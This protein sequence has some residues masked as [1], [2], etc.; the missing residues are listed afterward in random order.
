MEEATQRLHALQN[1]WLNPPADS[2][3]SRELQ[4]RTLI[5]LYNDPP[6]WP[7]LGH[8]RLDEVVLGPP[9]YIVKP[10]SP[11]ASFRGA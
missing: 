8:K 1:S 11:T 4:R 10:F 5:N 2:V 7:N 9:D 6:T 3:G